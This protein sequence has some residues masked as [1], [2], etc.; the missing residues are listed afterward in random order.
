M[1]EPGSTVKPFTM[2]AALESG[3]FEPET[4]INTSPGYLKVSYKTFVDER[5]YGTLDMA[6]VLTKSSQVGTTKIALELNPETTRELFERMGF[7]EG[8]AVASAETAGIFRLT[9]S[10]TR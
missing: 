2:L 5:D 9:A 4:E 7:G 6:G 10:G 1:M 8:T 3:K